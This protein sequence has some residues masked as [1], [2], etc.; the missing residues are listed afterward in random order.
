[1]PDLAV[2]DPLFAET[3]RHLL[4]HVYGFSVGWAG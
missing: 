3:F 1:M 4:P 2:G